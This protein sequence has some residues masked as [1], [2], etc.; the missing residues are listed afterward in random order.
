M[1]KECATPTFSPGEIAGQLTSDTQAILICDENQ[2]KPISVCPV[3][4]KFQN[5]DKY[6]M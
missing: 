3:N 1:F 4:C 2:S 6:T 5:D